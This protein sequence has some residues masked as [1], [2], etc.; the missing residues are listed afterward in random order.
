MK[1]IIAPLLVLL[2][3]GVATASWTQETKFTID[4][5]TFPDGTNGVAVVVITVKNAPVVVVDY[6]T[7]D[8]VQ[9]LGRYTDYSGGEVPTASDEAREFAFNH[10]FDKW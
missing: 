7:E 8:S 3:V 4:P 10:Y 1:R 5:I 2:L 6:Y 9:Y